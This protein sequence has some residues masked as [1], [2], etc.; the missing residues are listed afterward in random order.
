LY[1]LEHNLWPLSYF[2]HDLLCSLWLLL[3]DAGY[4]FCI[5]LII[6]CST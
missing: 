3:I 6:H 2:S 4:L 5:Y 1:M